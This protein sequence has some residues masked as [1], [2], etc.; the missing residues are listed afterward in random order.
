MAFIKGIYI[1]DIYTNDSNGYKVGLLRVKDASDEDV[2]N[3]VL[4]FTGIFDDL[5]YKTTYLMNGEFV[6]HN[7]YGMQFNV[8]SYELVL[9]T[10]EEEIIEFLSSEIFPIGEKTAQ[11][12]VHKLGK[13]TINIIIN[14]PNSLKGIP[15]L[16][17]IKI[18]KIV[19]VLDDYQSTSHIVIE[20]NKIGF[21]THDAI[22]IL[23][24]YGINALQVIDDNIYSIRDDI[25]ISFVELDK[26]ALNYGY[27]INDER[28]MEA[29]TLY[30][31][32]VI[33]F[34]NGDTYS[35]FNEIYDYVFKNTLNIDTEYLE[36]ILIKLS[37][38]GKVVIIKDRYYL[39][40][41]YEAEV[42]IARRLCNLN[43]LERRKLPKLDDKIRELEFVSGITY[44]DSQ[45]DAIK[46]ALNNNLTI[47]TG[48]PGTGKTTIIRCIVRL[49]TEI[50]NV[51]PEK[52]ALLAPTGRAARKLMDTT[53]L[54]A[55]TIHKYLGWDMDT[56]EFEKN[57]YFPNKEEYIIVDEASM[58]DTLLME[59]LLKG[60][61]I[62]A[63]YIFVGDYYQLPSVSQGQVLKDIIDAN[64]LDV[65]R[66]NKLYR[67]TEDSYINNLAY[68]IKNKEL[69]EAYLTKYD[70]YNFIQCSDNDILDVISDIIKKAL[71]KGY[72]EKD[73]QVLAPIYKT[74]NGIDA[75]NKMLQGLFNPKSSKKNEIVSGDVI[76]RE[77]DKILQL[78]ND[79]DN[80]ISNGDLGYIESITSANKTKSKKNEVVINF[81]GI[82]VTYT[83]KD[84]INITHG[85][86]ISVHKSQGGEFQMVIMP[87][88]R[89]F[90]RMLYNKLVYTAVTR[91][92]NSLI[93]VGDVNAFVYGVKNDLIDARKTTLKELL[94]SKY[95]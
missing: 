12:I 77:G 37:K 95:N 40:E 76:Y 74:P 9:P 91:A 34:N 41:F 92:K 51:K 38:Q 36:Y 39:S 4:T 42:Y 71:D 8:S 89:S 79:S 30:A 1:Q 6:T 17:D 93:L 87:F 45:K 58:I 16:T 13:D 68:E 2:I 35:Y 80:S 66:L 32:S 23:K 88:S 49:L 81:D 61:L 55:F 26:I 31:I 83:P 3:K 14:D 57:E 52:L 18:A 56:N 50:M 29:L 24:K 48:G 27:D 43:N 60:T 84:F 11:K 10:E 20:L 90:K 44:D 72:T 85:Y 64:V 67:Q 47:I 86:A 46:R 7:K 94:E 5:K 54:P 73:I 65:V 21:T 15:R 33:T 82:R 78:V 28:R 19:E 25:D 22:A 53:G 70:D 69:S 63:K 62:S 59:S 75:L